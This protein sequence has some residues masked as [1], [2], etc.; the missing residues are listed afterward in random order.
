M[1]AVSGWTG[2]SIFDTSVMVVLRTLGLDG[3]WVPGR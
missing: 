3:M 2:I 1:R